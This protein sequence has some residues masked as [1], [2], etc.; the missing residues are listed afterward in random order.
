VCITDFITSPPGITDPQKRR[1]LI[2]SPEKIQRFTAGSHIPLFTSY[3]LPLMATCVGGNACCLR[4]ALEWLDSSSAHPGAR[5][6]RGRLVILI[7]R[8]ESGAPVSD[9]ELL[10]Q[11]A[12]LLK[13]R[14]SKQCAEIQRADQLSV[15]RLCAGGRLAV[16]GAGYDL[17]AINENKPVPVFVRTL[18]SVAKIS[19]EFSTDADPSGDGNCCSVAGSAKKTEGHSSRRRQYSGDDA[20]RDRRASKN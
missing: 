19:F 7:M 2:S 1:Q 5:H 15:A 9:A 6:W 11:I 10:L 16:R 17:T 8:D 14:E 13:L 20:A 18:N 4:G 12:H 3:F